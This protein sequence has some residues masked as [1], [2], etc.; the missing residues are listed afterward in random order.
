[1]R[2]TEE[3]LI[4]LNPGESS[5]GEPRT[6]KRSNNSAD[7]PR[8]K[9]K[10]A[11]INGEAYVTSKNKAIRAK[12]IGDPCKCVKK[13]YEMI[14]DI[15]KIENLTRFYN[16]TTK[17][18]QDIYLQELISCNDIKRRRVIKETPLRQK[19][20]IYTVLIG[21]EKKDVCDTAFLGLFGVTKDRV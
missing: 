14:S 12:G 5:L 6:K 16:L 8:N 17:N 7:Y 2:G 15:D 11:R 10:Q 1:M 4:L 3:D 18:E 21:N 9:V 19:S 13:C 20:F